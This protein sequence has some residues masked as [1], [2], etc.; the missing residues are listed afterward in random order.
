MLV[1]VADQAG[2]P[3]APSPQEAGL[4]L[5]RQVLPKGLLGDAEVGTLM[6][7]LALAQAPE[8]PEIL[9]RTLLADAR[10]LVGRSQG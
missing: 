3:R 7:A 4:W 6:R 2:Q 9:V 5:H 1:A 10:N 8:L